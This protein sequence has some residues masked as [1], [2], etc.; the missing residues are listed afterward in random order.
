MI[1]GPSNNLSSSYIQS[2]LSSGL[3]NAGLSTSQT[4]SS[5]IQPDRGQL[6]PFGQVFSKLQ[7]LQQTDPARFS[8]VTSQISTNLA[9]AAQTAQA[10]GNTGAASRL[11]ALST[12]FS[13]ASQS[14]QMPDFQNVA[15]GVGGHHHHHAPAPTDSDS[16]NSTDPFLAAFQN[17]AAQNTAF[18]PLS[19]ISN[20]IQQNS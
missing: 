3:Q 11:T 4:T 15:H 18:D 19:I 6:S 14:G 12:D 8:Q 2:I 1:T 5:S 7:Q 13:N 20:T 17:N 16:T 9:N 10:D